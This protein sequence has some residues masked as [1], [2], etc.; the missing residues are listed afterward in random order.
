[1]RRCQHTAEH[2]WALLRSDII[3]HSRH[4]GSRHD[5]EKFPLKRHSHII[6]VNLNIIPENVLSRPS[7]LDD[8]H[9]DFFLSTSRYFR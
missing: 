4:L 9:H 6:F 1:M 7:L 8:Y 3:C 2:H 5:D